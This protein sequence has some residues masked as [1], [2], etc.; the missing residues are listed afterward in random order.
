MQGVHRNYPREIG[1]ES[2]KLCEKGK[3]LQIKALE[4]LLGWHSSSVP[5]AKL[6]TCPGLML[7][8]VLST[9]AGRVLIGF[10][11]RATFGIERESRLLEGFIYID[12][13]WQSQTL[14]YHKGAGSHGV[15]HPTFRTLWSRAL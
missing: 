8:E 5:P 12:M 6:I 14:G 7:W 15:F 2:T 9:K 11:P 13:G 1:R 10:N 4:T 3:F